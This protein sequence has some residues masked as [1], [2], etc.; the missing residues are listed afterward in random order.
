MCGGCRMCTELVMCGSWYVK[1]LREMVVLSGNG[2][3]GLCHMCGVIGMYC[4]LSAC[5]VLIDWL[6]FVSFTVSLLICV[7][8][9]M[10]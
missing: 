4:A 6:C 7:L 10:G 1:T 2:C 8:S 3:L 5:V 9:A